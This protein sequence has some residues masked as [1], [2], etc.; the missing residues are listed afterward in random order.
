MANSK[1][2]VT[3]SESSFPW[4]REALEF[5]RSAF[6]SHEP[7]RAWSNFEFIA[8][9]GTINEVDL[10]VFT[11]MGFYLIEIKSRPGRL[12]GDAGTWTWETE[13][14]PK[15]TMDNP[16]L[17][18]NCKAKKLR[19]LLRRQK[20]CKKRQK[21]GDIPFIEAI[22]F[23][24]HPTLEC[25]F[26]DTAAYGVR[27]RDTDSRSGIHKLITSR[28]CPGLRETPPGTYDK[29]TGKMIT[30][31]MEQAGIRPSERTRRVSDYKLDELIN[32]G[33]GYQDWHATHAS[34]TGVTRRVRI[35]NLHT[36]ASDEE[37]KAIERAARREAEL[38]ETLQHPG[39]L[40][41]EGFTE[42]ELGPALIFEHDPDAVRLDHFLTERHQ[43]LTLDHRLDLMRQIADAVRFAHE[44]RVVHRALCP[45]S[46]LVSTDRSGRFRI[47]VFNWQVGYHDG[48][49][50]MGMSR[51]VTMTSHVDG[52]V[53]DAGT[54]YMAPEAF[55][56]DAGS[57]ERLDIFSLGAIAYHIFSGKPPAANGIELSN[58]LRV[59]K[60][61]QIS[62]V[63]NG[64][65]ENLQELI[66]SST[67]AYVNDRYESVNEFLIYLEDVE[68]E[69]TT[70]DHEHDFVTN[71]NHAKKDD[72]LPGN[73]RVVRRLGKGGCSVVF[74]VEKDG[75][76]FVLKAA[77][78]PSHNVRLR[79][80]VNTLNKLRHNR[81]VEL[82]GTQEIGDYFAFLMRPIFSDKKEGRIET[83]RDRLHR[84]GKLHIDMLDRFGE[85]LL[86]VLR[87][88]EE[89]AGICHR[90]VKPDNIAIGQI[91]SGDKLHLILFDF[92][93]SE[94]PAD[95]IRAGTTGYLDPLLPIRPNKRFDLEAERYSVAATLYELAAGQG[96]LPRWGDGVSDP[97]HLDCEATIDAELFDAPLRD[98]LTRFFE[99]AFRRD[100][101]RRFDNAEQ[102]LNAWRDCF[103]DIQRSESLTDHADDEQ[104]QERLD[105]ATFE[106]P[107]AELGL[108]TSATDALDR[109]NVLTVKDLLTISNFRLQR[110][111]GVSGRT[112]KEIL[113]AKRTLL[114]RLGGPADPVTSIAET[115]ESQTDIANLSVDLIAQRIT[116]T[117][118]RDGEASKATLF[119][120]LGLNDQLDTPWPSQTDVTA[121]VDVT[122]GRVGQLVGKLQKRWAKD[123][124]VNKL[125]DD[126]DRIMET[127]GGVMTDREL[128]AAVLVAR[129]SAQDEPLRTKYAI[130]VA[131]ACVEVER[132]MIEPRYYVKRD[133]GQVFITTSQE[134]A[135][136]AGK[137]GNEADKLADAD[138]L[139]PPVRVMQRLRDVP[140]PATASSM[141]DSRLL[142]LA[143]AASDH[144]VVSSRQELYPRGMDAAR[145]LKLS[146]GA[147][148][149]VKELT[150]DQ[151]KDRVTGR[152]PE[153]SKLPGRPELD[154]LLASAG[155]DFNWNPEG[156]DGNGCYVSPEYGIHSITG[157]S[158]S[159]S[160]LPT[161]ST[162]QPLPETTPEIADARQFEERLERGIKEGSFLT[163][164]VPPKHYQCAVNRITNQ[165]PDGVRLMDFEGIFLD[166]LREVADKAGVQWDLVVRTDA[167]P[168]QGDWD[169]LM[170]L[171]SRAMPLVEQRFA[172]SQ[173]T[174][175][176]VYPGLLARYDQ[177]PFLERLRERIGRRDGVHGVWILT[178]GGEHAV[179]DG[180]PIPI[181]SAGQ[182]AKVPTSWLENRHRSAAI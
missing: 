38:L 98:A 86:N 27:L 82:C 29:P 50:S 83:L 103:A 141:T 72:S 123:A 127:V 131:R 85:D 24:S 109:A 28:V 5:V 119:A 124:A 37:R 39:I 8:D 4:E 162:E 67:R 144:A 118:T 32:E 41:R 74:L 47:K 12:R 136:Y 151:I 49:T 25:E 113:K 159:I 90:D 55:V 171:V 26:Q 18:A 176:I 80:E 40:R 137:L 69:A 3:V 143:A 75:Q 99:Q 23:C 54:A 53:E 46:I 174:L 7:Y 62:S 163:L 15:A 110:L 165:F 140:A 142:H 52:L 108:G 31:A 33:P 6:P 68:D 160:P 172:S 139:V 64:A 106:T 84:E 105:A 10:L 16:L 146:Q 175:F 134:L 173:E 22:V 43:E 170:I 114:R 130:A 58:K 107:I 129:G 125:R 117:G 161:A 166:A 94:L 133:R 102:M 76:Q 152:Y 126:I 153:A 154:A 177:M 51:H 115:E 63:L 42:H 169:K 135:K 120:L 34:L 79:A 71:P 57:G 17:S 157:I 88:L 101:S 178:A 66:Q 168:H 30:Q 19:S 87:Y 93:L 121:V 89:E 21:P 70:P 13:G 104:L 145:A 111:R 116:K 11:R 179:M 2:W 1:N 148:F 20:A 112:T 155:M 9:D 45:Q 78:D 100:P 182:R 149:G 167:T 48:N 132:S 128:G 138:P 35:Y 97:S 65:G 164:M 81:I 92:S 156:K 60:A 181:I 96:N 56:H 73:Y 91:I 180:K 95:N 147:L 77:N 14:K 158:N 44:K 59:T 36:Q 61:L 122:R 150:V